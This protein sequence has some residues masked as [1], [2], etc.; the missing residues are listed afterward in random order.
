LGT[1]PG[2]GAESHPDK[3]TQPSEKD[4]P[5]LDGKANQSSGDD[6]W[7]ENPWYGGTSD[8]NAS[9]ED[10]KKFAKNPQPQT[11]IGDDPTLPNDSFRTQLVCVEGG[12]VWL[13]WAWSKNDKGKSVEPPPKK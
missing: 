10:K 8:P 4:R 2:H 11:K 9:D 12:K 6:R 13:T 5:K 7:R 3:G 1:T